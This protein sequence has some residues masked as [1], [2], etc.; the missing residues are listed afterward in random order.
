MH[1]RQVATRP[2][3]PADS[4]D[5]FVLTCPDCNNPSKQV[6]VELDGIMRI[7]PRHFCVW[8]WCGECSIGG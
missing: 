6:I 8:G 3:E 1:G 4:K 7:D 2:I 5:P